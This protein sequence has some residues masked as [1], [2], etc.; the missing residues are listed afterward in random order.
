[1]GQVRELAAIAVTGLGASSKSDAVAVEEPLEIRLRARGAAPDEPKSLC[2]TMRTPGDDEDL[3]HGF[4]LAEGIV[5]RAAD[6]AT[7][8]KPEDD[9]VEVELAS[10]VD[11]AMAR[12]ERRF[13]TTSSCG[14]CGKSSLDM[15]DIALPRPAE[16][17]AIRVGARTIHSLPRKAR[18]AQTAFAST[19][20]LH[21]TA[22]FDAAG[23]L[24]DVREDVGRHNAMDK[25][26]GAALRS[27]RV[28]LRGHVLLVSGRASFEL[29]Q[30][31]AMAQAPV[32]CAV[33]A[34]SSL[35]VE[36]A[37]RAGMTLIGFLRDERFNVYCGG[38][39]VVEIAGGAAQRG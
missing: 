12:A 27:G 16:R 21:A 13:T 32:L 15:L 9:V 26:V 17:D 31:A 39:R 3:V 4:L 14:V 23:N 8:A 25:V 24:L 22:L 11:A 19:G 28:P 33:G 2:L 1:M 36:L 5:K 37:E 30:K 10:G 7:V 29:V 6:I 18:D 35:A 20:G 38:D 34:P